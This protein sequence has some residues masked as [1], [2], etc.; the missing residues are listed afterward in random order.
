MQKIKINNKDIYYYESDDP[1]VSYLK[2]G[3]LYGAT[4]ADI[5]ANLILE[6]EGKILDCGAHIGT[7]AVRA[8]ELG[9]TINC[10]EGAP[11][12][13]ECLNKTFENSNT[14]VYQAILSDSVKKCS[15]SSLGGPFGWFVEDEG[16]PYTSQTIDN[17]TH[18]DKIIGIK[19]DI[20]GGE[21]A[22]LQGARETLKQ[23][24]P[25][26][27]EVN[28]HCLRLI[29][30]TPQ[31]MFN[32]L[33]ELNYTVW[34]SYNGNSIFKVDKDK[35]Y[36]FCVSDIICIHK[37]QLEYY[38]FKNNRYFT[39]EEISLLFSMN[40]KNSNSDCKKYFESVS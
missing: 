31:D 18:T 19:L 17:I 1:V 34:I 7:F 39:D 22:A 5:L 29:N 40:M 13:I 32:L 10:I 8:E 11:Q 9:Y 14:D 4:N 37:D 27:I 6:K 21:I 26:L 2:K 3:I 38:N 33:D 12:N 36:P 30:K 15:F 23:K 24:P 28:G 16:G 25:M 35:K 20:E